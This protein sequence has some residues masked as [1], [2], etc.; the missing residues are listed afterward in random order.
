MFDKEQEKRLKEM[1]AAYDKAELQTL[2]ASAPEEFEFSNEFESSVYKMRR[3][4]INMT[5]NVKRII[6]IAA[7]LVLA[8][9]AIT[10]TSIGLVAQNDSKHKSTLGNHSGGNVEV[11]FDK[12]DLT[13]LDFEVITVPNGYVDQVIWERSALWGADLESEYPKHFQIIV[14]EVFDDT[15][16]DVEAGIEYKTAEI[17]GTEVII[18]P[19]IESVEFEDRTEYWAYIDYH[20]VRDRYYIFAKQTIMLPDDYTDDYVDEAKISDKEVLKMMEIIE[21]QIRE[22]NNLK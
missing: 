11:T 9:A 7:A 17:N 6:I 19:Y 10:A 18:K 4:D 5:I 3:K 14:D 8:I 16:I 21:K 2:L 1:L 15:V 13:Q 22:A 20:F 12:L